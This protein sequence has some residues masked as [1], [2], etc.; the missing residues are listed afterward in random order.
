MAYK[1]NYSYTKEPREKKQ[2]DNDKKVSELFIKALK[3]ERA[4]WQKPWNP[5]T[6][7]M[8]YNMFTMNDKA[9]VKEYQGYNSIITMLTREVWLQSEDPR[10]ITMGELINYNQKHFKDNKQDYFY[11]K[12]GEEATL[13]TYY[14]PLYL[15]KQNKK[16]DRNKLSEKEFKERLAKTS[17][18]LT[19]SYIFNASQTAKYEFDEEGK[20]KKDKNGK[21]I[22]KEN[23]S[24]PYNFTKE[25][26]RKTEEDFKDKTRLDVFIKNL[27]V[28]FK[29]DNPTKSFYRPDTDTI[30]I[31]PKEAFKNSNEYYQTAF[32]E[33][34]HWTGNEKRLNRE[35]LKT[36]SKD[37]KSRAREEL[38]AEIGGY[39][40]CQ[41]M[42]VSFEPSPN[43][44]EYVVGWCEHL[45]EKP[46]AIKEACMKAQKAVNYCI[47]LAQDNVNTNENI[48]ITITEKKESKGKI[49]S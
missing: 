43:N 37:I 24:I 1:K 17:F 29:N 33:I 39:L 45:S 46:D 44:K 36:Y 5:I 15:D 22:Y 19:N 49:R 31:L 30:H 42:G 18:I 38:V 48:N 16:L 12:Q 21:F 8:D 20:I 35:E 3:E 7:K 40:M 47:K 26:I 10:W 13:I 23:S 11:V 32:H 9:G 14:S 6:S 2:N 34:I 41:K 27:G 28:K 25:Q 4:P